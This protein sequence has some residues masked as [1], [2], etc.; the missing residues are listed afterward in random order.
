MPQYL[1][2]MSV[3]ATMGFRP[4]GGMPVGKEMIATDVAR[5]SAGSTPKI[6]GK[7][8]LLPVRHFVLRF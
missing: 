7:I 1:S 8:H 4:P 5:T 6:E 3:V 2:I